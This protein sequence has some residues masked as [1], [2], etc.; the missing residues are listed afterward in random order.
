MGSPT[1][2]CDD[3]VGTDV[4]DNLILFIGQSGGRQRTE[5]SL[6]GCCKFRIVPVYFDVF[7]FFFLCLV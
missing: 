3:D 6:S 7:L 5:V 4:A 1:F 2:D